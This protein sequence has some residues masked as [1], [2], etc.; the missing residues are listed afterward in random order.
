MEI[1]MELLTWAAAEC[2][3]QQSGEDSV[4]RMVEATLYCYTDMRET[5]VQTLLKLAEIVEPVKNVYGFRR[6]PVTIRGKVI[7]AYDNFYEHMEF[8]CGEAAVYGITPEE[9][10]QE[11]ETLHPFNDGNGRVGAIMYNYLR[12]SELNEMVVPPDYFDSSQLTT[13]Q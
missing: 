4:P 6:Q 10:Y 7:P 2:K 1:T 8:L 12:G 11:F 5:W 3:R 9:W 13:E